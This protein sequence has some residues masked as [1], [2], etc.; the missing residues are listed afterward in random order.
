MVVKGFVGPPASEEAERGTHMTVT[1]E[2][3]AVL[4]A[5]LS[6]DTEEY[7]RLR[8]MLDREAAKVGYPSLIAAAFFK[9]VNRHFDK[10]HTSAADV[11]EF[12]ANV[13]A[14]FDETGEDVN[15]QAAEAMI[16]TALGEEVDGDFDDGTIADAQLT[17]LTAI[18]LGEQ[19]T[20]EDLDGFLADARKLADKWTD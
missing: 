14:R 7:K 11:V 6:G 12:V 16:R 1:D 18:I 4:R 10:E 2:Q 17:V 19:L 9:A 8:N 13:R 3:V 5:H 20:G 15:P